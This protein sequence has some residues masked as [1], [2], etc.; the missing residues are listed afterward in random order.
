M[1]IKR[2]FLK[3]REDGVKLFRYYSDRGVCL[4]KVGTAEIYEE[5]VDVE[6][7]PYIYEE[8]EK[9]IEEEV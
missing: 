6:T 3:Q 5:A 8:T 4:H 2:D 9:I 1:A 7:A